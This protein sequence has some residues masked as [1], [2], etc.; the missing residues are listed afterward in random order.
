MAHIRTHG[1]YADAEFAS[2]VMDD[3]GNLIRIDN[4]TCWHACMYFGRSA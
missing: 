4:K 1:I 3:F 2:F